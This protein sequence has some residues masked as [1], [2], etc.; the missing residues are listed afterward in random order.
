[1]HSPS[2]SIFNSLS[3]RSG[4]GVSSTSF[5][6]WASGS[7]SISQAFGRQKQRV[8]QEVLCL[9]EGCRSRS[10]DALCWLT[11]SQRRERKE[12]IKF[13]ADT[14]YDSNRKETQISVLEPLFNWANTSG[15]RLFADRKR[16][17]SAWADEVVMDSGAEGAA[18]GCDAV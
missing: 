3:K 18:R 16:Q 12:S 1:M 15:I 14:P 9:P 8:E 13:L 4:E 7:W 6:G 10:R 17:S 11:A 5:G 2:I